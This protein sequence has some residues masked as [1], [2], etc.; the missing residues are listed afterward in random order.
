MTCDPKLKRRYC[1]F[2]EDLSALPATHSPSL[3]SQASRWQSGSN[4][5][6]AQVGDSPGHPTQHRPAGGLLFR[7]SPSWAPPRAR[8][9]VSMGVSVATSQMKNLRPRDVEQFVQ[10]HTAGRC[11][12]GSG[13]RPFWAQRL[14]FPTH[15]LL[16]LHAASPSALL[17][18]PDLTPPRTLPQ[19]SVPSPQ[20]MAISCAAFA[21]AQIRSHVRGTG[22]KAQAWERQPRSKPCSAPYWL[23]DLGL[24]TDLRSSGWYE[25]VISPTFLCPR[26]DRGK[27]S[28]ASGE[29]AVPGSPCHA[30]ERFLASI[31]TPVSWRWGGGPPALSA[32]SVCPPGLMP[33]KRELWPQR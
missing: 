32:G 4:V 14:M 9:L 16:P 11:L 13:H 8:Q 19:G 2:I 23:C 15:S 28:P 24:V 7:G 22:F 12:P 17:T 26:E 20:D 6:S 27:C 18:S 21:P 29:S 30:G 10:S 1:P 33:T 31:H 3:S 5:A 25:V